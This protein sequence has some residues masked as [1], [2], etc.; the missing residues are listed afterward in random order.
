MPYDELERRVA[1]RTAQLAEANERFE[2]VTKATSD[3]VYDWDLLQDTV[4]YSPRW[5]EMHG[6]QEAEVLETAEGWSLRIH[7]ED[8]ERVV[9]RL[10]A[11][12]AGRHPEYW[13]EYRIRRNDGHI[14]WVLDRGVARK[15]EQGHTVRMVG[16]ETDITWRK[17]AEVTIRRRA[18]EFRTLA[19]NV[20]ALFSYIDRDQRYRFVNKRY[21]ALFGRSAEEIVEMSVR[22]LLGP[23]SYA[24]VQV[25]LDS[26]FSGTAVSHEV[27]LPMS[28]ESDRWLSVQYVPDRNQEGTVVGLFILAADVT[29]LKLS[30]AALHEHEEQLRDLSA[31]LLE[32]Q[33]DERRRLARDLH[34]DFSQR[35][36]ALTLDLRDLCLLA[37]EPGALLSS[38][39]KTVGDVTEQLT[40]DLQRVA[41]R[42]HPS[43]LE[44]AGLEAACR[45]H[46]E[47]F[48]AQ[49]GLTVEVLVRDVP[50]TVPLKEATCLYRVLQE[51]LRNIRKHA[52]ATNVLV[53][54][55]ST[56]RGVGLCV[57]DDG[58]GIEHSLAHRDRKGLGLTS[59]S[60]RVQLLNGTFRLRTKPGEGTEVHA[61]VPLIDVK[62]DE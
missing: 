15:N 18:H 58:Q 23:E 19:D 16:S 38:R 53:R 6:F 51:S 39:L 4:Y 20:P 50:N 36:A 5:K 32:T 9:A 41:H 12:L 49:T 48:A 40:T 26:A 28:K 8:R 43:I 44:H 60:E 52:N 57:H 14:I 37:S 56:N 17:E 61:W 29:P 46:V 30:E 47:E 22:E 33:E 55:L 7:P 59:M 25:H 24:E 45:E 35:L 2:W 21:E 10:Q 13:E 62:S 42:L 27:R 54:L 1:E 11:Y 31:K 34:D 3:G